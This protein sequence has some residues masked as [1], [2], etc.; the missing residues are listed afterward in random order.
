[1]KEFLSFEKH[2]TASV[3]EVEKRLVL[4]REDLINKQIVVTVDF[5]INGT[6]KNLYEALSIFVKAGESYVDLAY[7][8]TLWNLSAAAPLAVLQ[9]DFPIHYLE[10]V[11][12][13][14]VNDINVTV[15]G[16]NK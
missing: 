4:L 11:L 2:L 15:Y 16:G 6:P 13:P 7:A 9:I 1:M 3:A 5:G 10:I 8:T 14:Q 12:K